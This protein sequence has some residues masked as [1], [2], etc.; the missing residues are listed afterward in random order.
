M[1]NLKGTLQAT[2]FI[3]DTAALV[4]AAHVDPKE[5]AQRQVLMGRTN[6]EMAVAGI[7]IVAKAN[8][9][10]FTIVETYVAVLAALAELQ[11]YILEMTAKMIGAT[12]GVE[13]DDETM[14]TC[15]KTIVMFEN[16]LMMVM[17]TEGQTDRVKGQRAR[18]M[19][20]VRMEREARAR[21]NGH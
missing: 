2:K 9:D 13:P 1:Q 18:I 8:E 7:N 12:R 21:G 5:A 11:P 15:A 4:A 6:N 17:M 19:E 16:V 20:G 14:D 3:S 10:G